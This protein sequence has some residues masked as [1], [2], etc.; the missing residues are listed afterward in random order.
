MYKDMKTSIYILFLSSERSLVYLVLPPMIPRPGSSR[1]NIS[2]LF[3]VFSRGR[4]LKGF[5]NVHLHWR[6]PSSFK[7]LLFSEGFDLCPF[8]VF[9]IFM[10]VI[11]PNLF[12]MFVPSDLELYFSVTFQS[13]HCSSGDLMKSSKF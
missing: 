13:W 1:S 7:F 4:P 5:H 2:L 6:Q 12:I 9:V 3:K 8:F 11:H 10:I